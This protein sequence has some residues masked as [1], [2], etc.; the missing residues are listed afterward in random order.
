MKKKASGTFISA[1]VASQSPL[2]KRASS[3]VVIIIILND[4]GVLGSSLSDPHDKQAKLIIYFKANACVGYIEVFGHV[5]KSHLN[6][7]YPGLFRFTTEEKP[8]SICRK[9]NQTFKSMLL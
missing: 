1:S 3:N 2:D 9:V 8:C 5:L 4:N 7:P 6:C